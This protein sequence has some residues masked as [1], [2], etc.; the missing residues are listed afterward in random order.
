MSN[1]DQLIDIKMFIKNI[2]IVTSKG[3]TIQM[4]NVSESFVLSLFQKCNESAV[5][6]NEYFVFKA[7]SEPVN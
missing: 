1:L 5:T 2:T 3:D 7:I 6:M 4:E